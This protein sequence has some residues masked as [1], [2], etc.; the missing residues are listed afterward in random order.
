M[1]TVAHGP[2]LGYIASLDARFISKT[3]AS[4]TQNCLLIDGKLRVR[5]GWR[6]I[7][8]LQT[9]FAS[10]SGFEYVQGY[11]D[12]YT[13]VE[14]YVAFETVTATLKP[15]SV[16]VSTGARTEIKNGTTPLS[17]AAGAWQ[18]FAF[19]GVGYFFAVGDEVWVH[20][21]GDAT[22]WKAL[23]QSAPVDPPIL[24]LV[25]F[26][27][28]ELDNVPATAMS[29][30]GLTAGAEFT[31][32]STAPDTLTYDS[33]DGGGVL[34]LNNSN[35]SGAAD[36]MFRALISGTT[37]GIQD[38]SDQQFIEF[39]LQ[40]SAVAA[41]YTKGMAVP[42]MVLQLVQLV[43]ND[44][45]P[46][47]ITMNATATSSVVN[48]A[49]PGS[50]GS[51]TLKIKATFPDGTNMA[52][53]DNVTTLRVKWQQAAILGGTVSG[54]QT[55]IG[56]LTPNNVSTAAITLSASSVKVKYGYAWYDSE[57]G[58]ESEILAETSQYQMDL[59]YAS[60][61]YDLASPAVF[62][63]NLISIITPIDTDATITGWNLY[64]QFEDQ[65]VWRFVKE[66]PD[67]TQTY[68]VPLTAAQLR[69]LPLRTR[70]IVPI[71]DVVCACPFK[72][73]VVWGKAGGRL[74]IR[75]SKVGFPGTLTRLADEIDDNTRGQDFSLA[76]NFGDEPI[77][78]HQAG[79][80]LI[81]LGKKGAYAQVGNYPFE[82]TPPKKLP[83][84]SGAYSAKSSC[85]FRDDAGNW[86][87]AYLA[88]DGQNVWF[89]VVSNDF[90]GR[91][92]FQL[93][94]L[95]EAIR[96]NIRTFLTATA[97]PTIGHMHMV[98]DEREEALW[99][100]YRNRAFIFRKPSLLDGK[101]HWERYA[102]TVPSNNYWIH[103]AADTKWGLRG[104]RGTGQI[105]EVERDSSAN[106]EPIEG[107][108]RDGGA[109][110][111]TDGT[112]WEGRTHIG[113]NRRVVR[114]MVDRDSLTDL[115]KV[116]ASATRNAQTVTLASGK[117]WA[118][119]HFLTQGWEITYRITLPVNS[120]PVNG[121]VCEESPIGGGRNQ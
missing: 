56:M 64:V 99:L 46:K 98:V 34:I 118:G 74:N 78:M 26:E 42:N 31:D 80:A 121:L 90:N 6:N 29:W 45:T 8:G 116:T 24:P 23:D 13:L 117:R 41:T 103:W 15:Y 47:T 108:L 87:V 11:N 19:D 93:V 7:V 69:E 28:T 92:G 14:E 66:V 81:I 76:D 10:C 91:D 101:R 33:V 17:L 67:S 68:Q 30:A 37:A 44:G 39:E 77:A 110:E 35:A 53:W 52:E 21:I 96:G 84:S 95:S 70:E 119:F 102:Y 106:F 88:A 38:W 104:F 36:Y 100:I 97:T 20:S 65:G 43:N 60:R 120:S 82:M 72:G 4:A 32:E 50:T 59:A 83:G 113:R 73:W 105:D 49:G 57:R 1:I 25:D 18:G 55:R 115:V 109:A 89:A 112:Y 62:L 27:A 58:F 54:E 2:F 16:H 51:R 86:G 79:D 107:A 5:R 94:E 12:S 40:Y 48:F 114:V 9:N 71:G 61:Y 85:R 111:P 22:S 3:A 75:H 63:G